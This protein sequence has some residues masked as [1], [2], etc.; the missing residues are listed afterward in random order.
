[1]TGDIDLIL[2]STAGI[3]TTRWKDV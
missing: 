1:V 2:V 3:T